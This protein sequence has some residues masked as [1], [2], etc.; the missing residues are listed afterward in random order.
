MQRLLNGGIEGQVP[1]AEL[2]VHNGPYLPGPGVLGEYPPLVTN[3]VGEAHAY[4]PFPLLWYPH[5][6]TYM[7]ADPVPSI[8][9]A[10]AGKDIEA[11][12]K[13]VIEALGDLNGLMHCMVRG[14]DAVAGKFAAAGR[15]ISVELDHGGMRING[16]C[17]INL[18]FIVVLC[19]C[20]ERAGQDCERNQGG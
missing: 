18:D 16:V 7:V 13:P 15:E 19:P 8:T 20:C 14:P 9:G 3:F 2:L 10:Q 6:R 1:A 5:P 17:A 12:L 11:C 4:R